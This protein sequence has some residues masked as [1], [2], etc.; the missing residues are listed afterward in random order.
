MNSNNP[1]TDKQQ[2]YSIGKRLKTYGHI[3]LIIEIVA[4]PFVLI[5]CYLMIF[6]NDCSVSSV[7]ICSN[8]EQRV[9][10]ILLAIY[11]ICGFI[12][13]IV[14]I[15]IGS[16]IIISGHQLQESQ[17]I[18]KKLHLCSPF[19]GV[20]LLPTFFSLGNYLDYLADNPAPKIDPLQHSIDKN[21]G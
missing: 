20:F 1:I 7:F 17:K 4:A 19:M 3:N 18:I 16:S 13:S 15:S 9:L 11:Y 21:K 12:A 5:A 6:P 14:L 2:L 10:G 8:P